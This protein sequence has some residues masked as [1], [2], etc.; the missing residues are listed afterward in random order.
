MNRSNPGLDDRAS[1]ILQAIIG[2]YILTGKPVGS[3]KI[4]K[5]YN[6]NISPA[7]A[8]NIMAD[9]EDEGYLGHPHTSAGR[10]PTDLGYRYYV[11]HLKHWQKLSA[12]EADSLNACSL[13][14]DN[15]LEALLEEF[16]Q[17]LSVLSNCIGLVME[18]KISQAV[19]KK[20][21]FISIRPGRVLAVLI[22]QWG[23]AHQKV[24]TTKETYT[25]DQLDQMA[26]HINDHLNG[27]SLSH[28]RQK[29]KNILQKQRDRYHRMLVKAAKLSQQVLNDQNKPKL[30]IK[31]QRHIL[32]SP[33]FAD[34]RKL[35]SIL[36]ALEAKEKL[37]TLLDKC[38]E[39]GGVNILIGSEMEDSLME[40]LSL[41]ISSYSFAGGSSG[42][43]GVIGPTR[44][45]YSC[46]IP[47]VTFAA[48]TMSERLQEV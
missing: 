33:E 23:Y 31:G 3:R 48:Q 10:I 39:E 5:Q 21:E 7:T 29:L 30:Y 37:I 38:I 41:I 42:M 28:V 1:Q 18:P 14:S 4:C 24:I 45:E 19:F 2:N 34:T 43:L 36:N 27:L 8:R 46:I 20:I 40:N 12:Y 17:K 11:D 9:L 13:S 47:M 6:L 25:Q 32:V 26:R 15:S 16:S 22:S 44:L 35:R